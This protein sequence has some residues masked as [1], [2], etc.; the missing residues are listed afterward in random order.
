M[1]QHFKCSLTL[2]LLYVQDFYRSTGGILFCVEMQGKILGVSVI[3]DNALYF[4][5]VDKTDWSFSQKGV[6]VHVFSVNN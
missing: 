6:L 2:L 4:V 5:A 3:R 1:L